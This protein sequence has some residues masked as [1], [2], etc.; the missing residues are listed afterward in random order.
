VV[1]GVSGRWLA[2]VG[3]TQEVR[4]MK[5]WLV[6][7]GLVLSMIFTLVLATDAS[8]DGRAAG[9]LVSTEA[10]SYLALIDF[11]EN[12]FTQ[13]QAEELTNLLRSA[14][15]LLPGLLS[16]QGINLSVNVVVFTPA[17]MTSFGLG[18]ADTANTF[19]INNL[20]VFASIG[21]QAYIKAVAT[22]VQPPQGVTTG[23]N[24]RLDLYW[25]PI[26]SGS[27]LQYLGSLEVQ[28]QLINQL[29]GLL[30]LIE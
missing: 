7:G 21:V 17:E 28:E 27:S 23:E 24:I 25:L 1:Y 13:P 9:L 5:R 2:K 8:A 10:G 18:N 6:T 12:D 3:Q 4:V 26:G 22:K 19:I 30:S 11:D 20:N 15:T 16:Q 14:A 29:S